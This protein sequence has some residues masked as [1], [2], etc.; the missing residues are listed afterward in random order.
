[1]KNQV[2]KAIAILSA[3]VL[4][5]VP[6]TGALSANAAKNQ[7]INNNGTLSES[8]RH[9]FG[10]I[11]NDGEVASDDAQLVLN[12]LNKKRTFT[13][14]QK[15]RADVNADGKITE[16]DSQMILNYYASEGLCYSD[17]LGDADCN[18]RIDMNDSYNVTLFKAGMYKKAFSNIAADVNCDGVVNQCDALLIGRYDLGLINTLYVRFGDVDSNGII[19]ISD[20]V[21]L[22]RYIAKDGTKLSDIEKK[23]ADVNGDGKVTQADADAIVQYVAYRCFCWA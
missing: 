20:A 10:D 17:I 23:R 19:D 4:G 5:V 15:K 12:Y 21:K 3:T 2:K 14:D 18:G 16:A 6:M 1:M 22:S 11:N 8:V 7:V 9:Y 13:A